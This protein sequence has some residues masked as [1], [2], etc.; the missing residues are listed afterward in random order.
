MGALGEIYPIWGIGSGED[1][2]EGKRALGYMLRL[3]VC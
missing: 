3:E 2:R 1:G